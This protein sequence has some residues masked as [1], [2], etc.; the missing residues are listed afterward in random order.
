MI[1]IKK[2]IITILI[3]LSTILLGGI[4]VFTAMR[5][6]QLRREP[7]TPAQPQSTPSAML[8][9]STYKQPSAC[10]LLSFNVNLPSPTATPRPSPTPTPT[11][12]PSPTPNQITQITTPIPTSL[13]EAG[14]PTPTILGI[15]LGLLLLIGA[16]LL[17]I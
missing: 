13:P 2:N 12:S 4:A 10:M 9:E 6:Y 7:V 5:L 8:N 14:T 3:V 11:V 17:A 15:G 1:F 16:I